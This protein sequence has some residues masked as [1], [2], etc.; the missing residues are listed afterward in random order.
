MH[1]VLM[2]IRREYVERVRRK[3]FWFGT[4]VVP[5]VMLLLFLGQ[6]RLM[7][8]TT[9]TQ[10][11]VA[12]VDETGRLGDALE[13]ALAEVRLPDGRPEILLE[14]VE[15]GV[16]PRAGLAPLEERVAA[17]ELFGLL[18]IGNDLQRGDN[19]RFYTRNVAERS[20]T[21]RLADRLRG[22]VIDLRVERSGLAV[23]RG[24]LDALTAPVRLETFQV[25][26]TG[27]VKRKGFLQSYIGT[28]VFVM[29]LYT[30]LLLYGVSVL[31]GILEEKSNRVIEV[32][33]ASVTPG[34]LMTGKILGIGLVGLTQVAVYVITAGSIRAY[35]VSRQF[36]DS[37]TAVMDSFSLARLAYF[38]L[39]FVLGYFLFTSLFAAVGAVCNSEQEAQSL[40]S[41]VIFCLV[42]PMVTTF[43]FVTNPDSTAAVVVSLI[44]LFTPMVMFM[45]I[46][47]LAP[48]TWQILLS[49]VLTLAT[50]ALLFRAVA[51]VFRIGIL[52]YGKR[53]GLREILRW[54]R[55]G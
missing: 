17:G 18:H 23:D 53:P 1:D 40:Q 2:I 24:A 28:F 27:E 4:L 36:S 29:L 10:R 49:V 8:M 12:V 25:S 55:S 54:A 52:M 20:A 33:L 16:D 14:Q 9:A 15:P 31:R 44:P 7:S 26:E 41:P 6:M 32:L 21:R 42:V 48:P 3:Y 5:A 34:Q 39:F 46:S 37:W 43:F 38:V 30:S 47:V 51:R 45:R 11:R 22:A 35:V 50:I 13:E 19:F